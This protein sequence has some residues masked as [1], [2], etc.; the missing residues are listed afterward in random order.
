MTSPCHPCVDFRRCDRVDVVAL[1]PACGPAFDLLEATT[2]SGCPTLRV[3]CDEPAPNGVEGVVTRPPAA[4]ILILLEC[5]TT[6]SI[7]PALAKNARA[8]HHRPGSCRRGQKLGH[9]PVFAFGNPSPSRKKMVARILRY[10]DGPQQSRLKLLK[11]RG[12]T[13]FKVNVLA[14]AVLATALLCCASVASAQVSV[15]VDIG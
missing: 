4:P 11:N 13:M 6:D 7:L 15:G 8:G 9:P 1:S 2:E 5:H 3:L 14:F 12:G 10:Y